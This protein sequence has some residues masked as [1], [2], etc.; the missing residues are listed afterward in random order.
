MKENERF[1]HLEEEKFDMDAE[2]EMPWNAKS[3][4]HC[5]AI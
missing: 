4:R 2:E 5:S 3:R 1:G